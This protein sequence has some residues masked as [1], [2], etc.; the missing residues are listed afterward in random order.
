[1]QSELMAQ[2]SVLRNEMSMA[3]LE[4]TKLEGELNMLKEQNQQLDLNSVRL[5]S[6]Y[7]VQENHTH[8]SWQMISAK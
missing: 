3:Q 1:M 5:N 7:Q 2:V 4:R 6:Q 8:Q